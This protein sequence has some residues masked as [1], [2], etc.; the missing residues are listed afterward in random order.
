MCES[1]PSALAAFIGSCN[2]VHD[3]TASILLSVDVDQFSFPDEEA[4]A[5]AF[6]DN[7]F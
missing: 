3:L 5:T 1:V 4:A 7:Y 2:S 6:S